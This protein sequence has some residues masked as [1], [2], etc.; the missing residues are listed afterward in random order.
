[1][2][3]RG[4]FARPYAPNQTLNRVNA[5]LP[6]GNSGREM[7]PLPAGCSGGTQGWKQNPRQ[8][9]EARILAL[10]GRIRD[11]LGRA[12]PGTQDAIARAVLCSPARPVRQVFAP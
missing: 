2:S 10:T 1:M 5:R 4:L 6:N 12:L 7:W 9:T 11:L 3:K 8:P